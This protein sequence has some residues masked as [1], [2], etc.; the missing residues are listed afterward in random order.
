MI[1][2]LTAYTFS[3]QDAKCVKH[4]MLT[5]IICLHVTTSA[6]GHAALHANSPPCDA[7]V[8]TQ[9]TSVLGFS[10]VCMD[11]LSA[12]KLNITTCNQIL[13]CLGAEA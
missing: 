7:S 3:R 4:N 8:G 1:L 12:Q 2:W 6:P 11:A 10:F 5:S 13:C 9:Y